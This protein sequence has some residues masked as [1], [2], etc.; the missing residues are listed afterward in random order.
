[1][2]RAAGVRR[3]VVAATL[4]LMGVALVA[5]GAPIVGTGS[6]AGAQ[7][8]VE[9]RPVVFPVVG[10]VTYVDSFGAPRSGGRTHIG[11]DLMGDK[12]QPLLAAVDGR[13]TWIRHDTVR[14]N[15]LI[16]TDDEGWRYHYVH[17]NN[18]SPGTDD[19]ANPWE[20]AFVGDLKVG[21]RVVAGQHV[22]FLGDSGNAEATLPHLHFEIIRPDGT[23]INPT[24]SV[25]A[26]QQSGGVVP[27]PT[28][29]A[30]P[31]VPAASVR[32]FPD[33]ATF[34]NRLHT[35][36]YGTTATSAQR[37]AVTNALLAD[38]GA[39]PGLVAT[40]VQDPRTD[41][42]LGRILRL[43]EAYFLRLPDTGGYA[44]WLE[45]NRRGLDL[46]P[47]SSFFAASPEFRARYGEL[48][49]AE[50]V[51]LVYANVLGRAPDPGGRA[52]WLDLLNR[53]RLD[54]GGLMLGFSESAE[55]KQRH[56]LRL[57]A[58]AVTWLFTEQVPAESPVRAWEQSRRSGETLA[59]AIGRA[60]TG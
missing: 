20:W 35:T 55:F 14:G 30:P 15:N 21:D 28:T 7:T 29:V 9:I 60:A 56:A 8:E 59:A 11:V 32:P 42:R 41:A 5:V 45:Q 34:V 47:I 19:G 24:P 26:A 43:Y 48:T 3:H 33:V 6:A 1:M 50:F 10:P 2:R 40:G 25:Q 53:R 49:N 31:T 39:L 18:D 4:T 58:V 38:P 52:Y 54:R 22:A 36:F 37:Q 57:E 12:L 44:Y 17:I 46:Y 51:D 27:V 13:V 23:A 16:I